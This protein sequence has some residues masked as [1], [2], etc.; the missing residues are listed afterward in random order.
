MAV[1]SNTAVTYTSTVIREDLSR[2]AELVSPVDTP[3]LTAIGK[4]DA[5]AVLHEWVQVEL[6]PATDSN[7]VAEGDNPDNDTLSEGV[8][9]SS[10]CQLS[11]KV[12][13]ISSTRQAVDEV[14]D[15]GKMS[16]AIAFK[17]KELRLDMEKHAFSNKISVGTGVRVAASI[18]SFIRTNA[19]RGTGGVNPTLSGGTYGY[20][21]AAAVDGTTRAFTEQ[22]LKDALQA[23]WVSG[24]DP[25]H[26]FVGPKTKGVISGFTGGATKNIDADD[27]K[28]VAAVDVYEGDWGQVRIIPARHIRAREVLILDP[29]LA[30]VAYLQPVKQEPLAKTGHSERRMISTEYCLQLEN[31][32]AAS[33]IADLS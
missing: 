14:G 26:A 16:K 9:L 13:Q 7:Q 28:I 29:S 5:S 1:P 12:A 17:L 21:N 15:L 23:V 27:R 20:P 11:D 2:V 22:M 18:P 8:R 10:Y 4:T 19:Q 24:G 30:K 33:I 6:A 3:L 31:E 25:T 32:R